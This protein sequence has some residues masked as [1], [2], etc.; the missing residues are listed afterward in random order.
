MVNCTRPQDGL[1]PTLQLND[2]IARHPQARQLCQ[3]SERDFDLGEHARLQVIALA[4]DKVG[5]PLHQIVIEPERDARP[6]P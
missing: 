6:D 4:H 5:T 2:L 1:A 3:P